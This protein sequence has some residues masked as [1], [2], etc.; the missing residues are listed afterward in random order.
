MCC[1]DVVGVGGR[2]IYT[3]PSIGHISFVQTKDNVDVMG[4]FFRR[5]QEKQRKNARLSVHQ[6]P[7][8]SH[9]SLK[10]KEGGGHGQRLSLC[11]DEHYLNYVPLGSRR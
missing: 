10:Q 11:G 2:R 8:L 9:L 1:G 6:P 7:A 4:Y 3:L 5:I